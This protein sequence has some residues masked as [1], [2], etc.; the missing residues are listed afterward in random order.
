MEL[1]TPAPAA[2]LARSALRALAG[3]PRERKAPQAC[4]TPEWHARVAAKGQCRD[5]R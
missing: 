5:C 2:R 4:R 1:P 3:R